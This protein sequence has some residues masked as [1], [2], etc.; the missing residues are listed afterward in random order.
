MIT[1]K[2]YRK[3][4][5]HGYTWFFVPS[6]IL[7]ACYFPQTSLAE[8]GCTKFLARR[9]LLARG[10]IHSSLVGKCTFINKKYVHQIT[11]NLFTHDK[12]TGFRSLIICWIRRSSGTCFRTTRMSFRKSALIAGNCMLC[13]CLLADTSPNPMAPSLA[14]NFPH[15]IQFLYSLA[16]LAIVHMW[17]EYQTRYSLY[18]M[19]LHWQP[20]Y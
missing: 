7:R 17:Q 6:D 11:A 16:L 1:S 14:T 12:F 15:L 18:T 4:E 10:S 3:L 2:E 8:N 9:A 20:T 13:R 5:K 19:C